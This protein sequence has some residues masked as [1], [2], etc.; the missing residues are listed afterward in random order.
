MVDDYYEWTK[1]HL[2]TLYEK[3]LPLKDDEL[4]TSV[5]DIWSIKKILFL[6]LYIGGYVPIIKSPN[7]KFKN[8]YYVD[9]HSGSGLISFKGELKEERFPGSP[10]VAALRADELPFTDY[11]LTDINENF[12]NILKQRLQNNKKIF[13]NRNYEP[14]V[15]DFESAVLDVEKKKAFGDAFLFF[16]DPIGYK[17]IK[18]SLMKKILD[19]MTAD[20]I[21]TFM[22]Y[23]IA[24]NR[25]KADTDEETA[26]SL[27]E[28][29][30]NK[31]WRDYSTGDDL[32]ELYRKQIE[33]NGKRTSVIEVFK[34]GET[35]LYDI[36]L[37]TRSKGGLKV[38]DY[39]AKVLSYVDTELI[40]S[41]FEVV[42][43]KGNTAIT[44]YMEHS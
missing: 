8:W 30:G 24:F 42:A 29:F 40:K 1:D 39:A 7:S 18:W 33:S 12:I 41:T 6:D 19:L 36:I 10:L 20:I 13:G 2:K 37:A 11:L 9:T 23:A 25:S 31:K 3:C 44:D 17:E 28:F 34:K 35:K 21:F 43:K 16:I 5:G 32:L 27:D 14:K 15:M 4:E 26:R 38:A 22:T